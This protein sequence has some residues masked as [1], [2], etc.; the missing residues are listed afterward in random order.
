MRCE[1][2]TDILFEAIDG[3]I[4][5]GVLDGRKVVMFGLNAPAFVCKQ[6]LQDQ[7][8][9]TFAFVDNSDVAIEQFNSPDVKPTRHHLIGDRRIR[10]YR[11]EELPEEY[12]NEYVFLVYSK[13]EDEMLQQL[14]ELG[15]KKGE[16]A[17]LTG[18]FW[19]TEA[20]KREYIPEGAGK[21]LTPQE[22]KEYQM[23]GLRYVH[24]LC[25]KHGLKYYLHYGTLLGAVRHKGYIPWDDD[26]DI[27]MM[28]EEMLELLDII[29]QENGRYGV[30][31][32]GFDDPV[33]HFIARIEDRETLYHQWDIPLETFG[34]MIVLDI[35]PMAGMP[36]G[37]EDAYYQEVLQYAG[38]YDDLTVE[39]SK[40]DEGIQKR[41][42]IC[43]KYVL[44]AL[45]QYKPRESDFLFTIP[46]K[47]GRLV[48][49]RKYWD[50]RILM[51]FEGYHFYGPV[52]YDGLLLSHY[53]Q[54]Y[55]IPPEENRR[56]SI[57]RTT[58]FH[59]A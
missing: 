11:P 15:Y 6:Y 23:A 55:M 59:K 14:S 18:G 27:L 26:L 24:D 51:E 5:D 37:Q 8:I 9:E 28:N 41:R 22:I 45:L 39:F 29:K 10:A 57:H 12:R 20:I 53:G 35:F 1:Y 13:Y 36:K 52:G 54:E 16:Q 25:E 33:R 44:D 46:T 21:L 2:M 4:R 42:E 49:E 17:F 48:F 31:Y 40:P 32:A 30:F 34:G 50:D 56:V 19:R 58:I 47:P 43:K 7:G 38:E 3:L